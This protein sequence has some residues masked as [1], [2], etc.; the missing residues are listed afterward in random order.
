M[1]GVLPLPV[2]RT[3]ARTM[4]AGSLLAASLAGPAPA[5]A[6][7]AHVHGEAVLEVSMAG[8]KVSVVLRGPAQVFFGFEHP[9]ATQEEAAAVKTALDALRAPA[10]SVLELSVPCA[11]ENTRVASPFSADVQPVDT[12]EADHHDA[13]EHDGHEHDADED[14]ADEHHADEDHTHDHGAD[15]HHGHADLEVEYAYVCPEAAPD[16]LT[17]T[18]FATF[19]QLERVKAAWI[20]DGGAGSGEVTGDA[21]VLSLQMR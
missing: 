15:E 7:A 8:D 14:H 13:H 2:P 9:P 11:L 12:S 3:A 1:N 10:R 17:V 18:A 16:A 4:L 6:Q 19:P 21:P 20:D 5:L